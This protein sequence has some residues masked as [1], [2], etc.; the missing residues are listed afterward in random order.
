MLQR[1]HRELESLLALKGPGARTPGHDALHRLRRLVL[2]RGIPPEPSAD[3]SG[4]A[5]V[6]GL[7]GRVW[8]VLL[9]VDAAAVDATE[10]LR[11]VKRGPSADEDAIRQDVFRTFAADPVFRARVSDDSITR[12]LHAFSHWAADSAAAGL[13]TVGGAVGAVGAAGAG[14]SSSSSSAAASRSKG[15]AAFRRRASPA[16][17]TS[18]GTVRRLGVTPPP[19]P[20]GS[21]A[22]GARTGS[23]ANAS[24]AGGGAGASAT[25]LQSHAQG[26]NVL[27]APLLFV[28]PEIDAFATFR[29]LVSR[30][31]PQYFVPGLPGVHKGCGLFQECLEALDPELA[32]HVLTSNAHYSTLF[33]FARLISLF[34]CRPPLAQ[35]I[36]LWDAVFAFGAHLN[37][38]LCVA[39]V[40][41]RRDELMASATPLLL[42]D[43]RTVPPLDADHLVSVA[44]HLA[45]RLPDELFARLVAHTQP[46]KQRKAAAKKRSQVSSERAS[47]S[48]GTSGTPTRR[49]G[50]TVRASGRKI[51]SLTVPGGAVRRAASKGSGVRAGRTGSRTVM[52]SA[53]ARNGG[54]GSGGGGDGSSADG[55]GSDAA[56]T[57]ADG[58][59]AQHSRAWESHNRATAVYL[60]S[61]I[62]SQMSTS[63]LLSGGAPER[64]FDA[65]LGRTDSI[66]DTGAGAGVAVVAPPPPPPTPPR[67]GGLV[68][69]PAAAAIDSAGTGAGAGGATHSRPGRARSGSGSSAGGRSSSK[70]GKGKAAIRTRAASARGGK[71]RKRRGTTGSGTGS[72]AGR[73]APTTPQVD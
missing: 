19:P 69:A 71:V 25:A 43:V 22:A 53:S 65:K 6:C 54:G 16:P 10:Y 4:N 39:E 40:L 11:L 34:A 62:L 49:A 46:P 32:G 23:T 35:L 68:V 3:G 9:G 45:C 51:G 27:C 13:T 5:E 26:F 66:E 52:S 60:G 73:A 44:S 2:V 33:G 58:G 41:L 18:S 36:R 29:V 28:M 15:A 50:G 42:L 70:G 20:A 57:G 61:T 48:Y 30:H 67:A 63:G 14:S 17:R 31:L 1:L 59:K 24:T 21:A 38:V 55:A 72:G 37:V 8:K 56:A 12:V 7:R 64:A 47:R